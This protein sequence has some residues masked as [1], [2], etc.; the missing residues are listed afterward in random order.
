MKT[1]WTLLC[2]LVCGGHLVLAS[3]NSAPQGDSE[4]SA[5]LEGH[6]EMS[7]EQ[8]QELLWFFRTDEMPAWNYST[9]ALSFMVLLIGVVLLGTTIKAN[10]NRKATYLQG[11]QS[12]ASQL[13]DAE[14]KQG[15]V[16]LKESSNLNSAAEHLDPNPQDEDQVLV[17][18][19]DGTTTSL[20]PEV[21]E[22]DV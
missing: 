3:G 9:L 6:V 20:Y 8:L 5:S 13:T 19:K 10:K 18:W 12:K 21:S 7:P 15:F 22:E 14:M 2:L 17:H 4:R 1:F 16:T 11:D